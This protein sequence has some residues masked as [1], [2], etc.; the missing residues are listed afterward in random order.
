VP[1]LGH[2]NSAVRLDMALA[3]PPALCSPGIALPR[4][5]TLASP[6]PP[7]ILPFPCPR[8]HAYLVPQYHHTD[9]LTLVSCLVS[10]SLEVMLERDKEPSMSSNL[11]AIWQLQ[12]HHPHY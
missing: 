12:L 10:L 2:E 4:P 9:M 7:T 11:Q 8:T 1:C 5:I 6:G 3:S